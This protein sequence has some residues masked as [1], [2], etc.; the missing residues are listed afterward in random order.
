M[1]RI[2]EEE[3]DDMILVGLAAVVMVIV[4]VALIFCR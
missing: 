4:V 2:T 1:Q 3:F